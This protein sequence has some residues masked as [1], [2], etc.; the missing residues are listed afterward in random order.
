MKI[1][2]L[3]PLTQPRHGVIFHKT[4]ILQLTVYFL[5]TDGAV[6]VLIESKLNTD[7]STVNSAIT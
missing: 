3:L 4:C 1:E 6:F 7:R 2:P 5:N